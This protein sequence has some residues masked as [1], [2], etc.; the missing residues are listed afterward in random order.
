MEMLGGF[1]AVRSILFLLL[2]YSLSCVF[3]FAGLYK[4]IGFSENFNLPENMEPSFANCM[5]YS[6]ATQA[7]CMAGEVSPKTQLGRT[8]LSFQILSAYLTTLVLIVPWIH[9]SRGLRA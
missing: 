7:T 1:R 6:F 4:A 5:Y 3:V 2:I 9:A 8:V